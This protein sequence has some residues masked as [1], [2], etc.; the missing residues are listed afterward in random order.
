MNGRPDRV[1]PAGRGSKAAGHFHAVLEPGAAATVRTRLTDRPLEQP[2]GGFDAIVEERLAEAD[3]YYQA[4]QPRGLD[5]DRRRVQR[6]AFAGLMWSKQFY[7]YS[8]ELWL[9]G[10]PAGP[11]PP[12]SRL[13]GRNAGWR[14]LYNLDVLSVPDKWEYPWFAAWDTA[15]HCIALARIDPEWAKRQVVLLLREWYMHPSGQLPAYEWDFADANPPV[16]AH[17]ALRVYQIDRD[18]SGREDAEF[19]E[20]VFH[21]LLLNF[22]WW[23]NRKDPEGRNAFQGGFLGLDNIGVFDRSHPNLPDGRRLEQADGTAWMG[24]F[25]LDMLKIAL[26]L[27][28]TRPAYESIATKFFE[29]FIAIANAINGVSEIGLWDPFDRFYYDVIRVEG[30]PPEHLRVRSFVG[31]IPLFSAMAIEPGTLERLPRFR[32]R[33]DWYLKYRSTHCGNFQLLTQPGEGGRT[34]LALA[35]REKLEAVIPRLLDPSQFLSDYGLRSLSRALADEPFVF[36][37]RGS[38]TSPANRPRRST[39]ATPTGGGR[40]GSRSTT[41]WSSP[42]ANIIAIT[43]RA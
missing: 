4:I 9:D 2:F 23:V 11:P 28:R 20:E 32:R 33:M 18:A 7:H 12:A 30:G 38:R 39:A 13:Q 6:Q 27:S 41:S 8:V 1:N 37:G 17:A 25:C 31:L 36:E 15:F 34:L 22:T 26:E 3:A 24:L 43:G 29:H 10:D 19:L 35:D 5:D 16:H 42:C 21:K 14:N 40:S